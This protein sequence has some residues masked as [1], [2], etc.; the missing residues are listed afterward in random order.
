MD[1]DEEEA[2]DDIVELNEIADEPGEGLATEI[3]L[4]ALIG[5]QSCSTIRITGQIRGQQ[6]LILIDSGSTHNF[7][8]M[9]VV[10]RVG[11]SIDCLEPLNVQMENGEI[12]SCNGICRQ[13]SITLE[14]PVI[15]D[16]FYPFE[17]GNVDVVLRVKWLALLDTVQAN[18]RHMFLKFQQGRKWFKICRRIEWRN[19]LCILFIQKVH[20]YIQ[21]T[22]T[23]Y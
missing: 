2:V 19:F 1:T 13:V 7:L 6:V 21:R 15:K 12:V 9:G 3:S 16:D 23:S 18:W 22:S 11:I 5:R 14:N 10:K 4:N 8:S 17:L 20:I